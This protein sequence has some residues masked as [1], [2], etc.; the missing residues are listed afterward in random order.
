MLE[1]SQG[2]E[3]AGSI[4]AVRYPSVIVGAAHSVIGIG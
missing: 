1:A 2:W 3:I 4:E